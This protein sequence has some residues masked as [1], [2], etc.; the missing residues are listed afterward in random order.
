[1]P[2]AGV[3][4]ATVGVVLFGVVVAAVAASWADVRPT[5]GELSPG[6]L[7]LAEIL[8]LCGLAAST[9]TWRV[10][11]S[12]F[13]STVGVR[14][15][16]RIYIIGQLGKYLPGSVWALAAQMELASRAGAPR[17]RALAASAVAI[18]VN[19]VT[20]LAVGLAVVPSVVEGGVLRIA[21]IGLVLLACVVGVSPAVLT[22]LVSLGLRALRQPPLE[23]RVSWR[24]I[25]TAGGWSLASWAAYGVAIW[26]LAVAVGAPAAAALP[27]SL[28]AIGLAMTVGFLVVVAPSGIGVR[29]AVIV[30]ALAP[31]LE[32]PAA[33]AVALIARLVF[34]AADLLA[35]VLVLALPPPR[36]ASSLR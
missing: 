3:L 22:R 15:A 17:P 27:V 24:G 33:L 4:R 26:V 2:L 29:E 35:A 1:M 7:A 30:A 19:V 36:V 21:T 20:G 11:L 5:L 31:V 16:S 23:R 32:A 10:S 34:T 13:G 6:A 12:E 8:V 9:L 28:A 14:S 25:L 18:A